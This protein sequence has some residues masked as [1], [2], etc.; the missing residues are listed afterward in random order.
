MDLSHLFSDEEKLKSF[1]NQFKPGQVLYLFCTFTEPPKEK[2][3]LVTST[4]PLILMFMI[5]SEINP[6]KAKKP[7]LLKAQ[8][9]ISKSEHN[10]LD[11]DSF[12]DCSQVV[13]QD[14]FPLKE[15]HSQ[16][17]KNMTRIKGMISKS[18]V[19]KILDEVSASRT[20]VRNEID[21][22]LNGFQNY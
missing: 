11:R 13:T 16:V 7:H 15:I 12:V 1:N 3:I 22:I 19:E 2:Y 8:V 17:L 9:S 14:D 20:L 6:F 10:F 5:N 21:C 18:L 4:N